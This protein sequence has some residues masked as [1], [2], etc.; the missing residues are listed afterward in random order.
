MITNR[1][2]ALLFLT[3]TNISE[4]PSLGVHRIKV[5]KL[6]LLCP[7]KCWC[8]KPSS[9]IWYPRN[10]IA[11]RGRAAW[12]EFQ[13]WYFP[14]THNSSVIF[15]CF[16]CF[17]I[18]TLTHWGWV[19]HVCVRKLTIIG[20]NN[21]LSPGKRQAIIWSNAGILL[22][23]PLGTE[24]REIL[25]KIYTFLFKKMHL[26][27]SGKW[28]LSCLGFSVLTPSKYVKHIYALWN[29]DSIGSSSGW[30]SVCSGLFAVCE[31]T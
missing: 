8:P 26:K 15:V 27:M 5:Y 4:I 24:L 16:S 6:N 20:S 18:S 28:P 10:S 22:M 12:L 3:H 11:F 21:G 7:S 23:G 13:M 25:I 17:H 1:E 2:D 19:M 31:T 9:V 14:R 30:S 29:L